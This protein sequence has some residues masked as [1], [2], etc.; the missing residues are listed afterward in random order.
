MRHAD[1]LKGLLGLDAVIFGA[2]IALTHTNMAGLYKLAVICLAVSG[3]CWVASVCYMGTPDG[4]ARTKSAKAAPIIGFGYIL[5]VAS[6]VFIALHL[7][8]LEQPCEN[9]A[10]PHKVQS[11][12]A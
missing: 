9:I 5:S 8:T 11:P 1:S 12:A 6:L 3:V 7:L 10:T 2:L 4:Y